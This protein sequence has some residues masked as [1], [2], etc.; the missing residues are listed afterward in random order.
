[1]SPEQ[2]LKSV[3]R[4]LELKLKLKRF[5]NLIRFHSCLDYCDAD[6]SWGECGR[7]DGFES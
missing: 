2:I 1:M 5:R 4:E 6:R 7:D 3:Y